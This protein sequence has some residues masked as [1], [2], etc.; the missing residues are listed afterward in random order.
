MILENV[1]NI[2]NLRNKIAREFKDKVKLI[3]ENKIAIKGVEEVLYY[4]FKMD[5]EIV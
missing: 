2:K 4:Q 3:L 1:E 5:K